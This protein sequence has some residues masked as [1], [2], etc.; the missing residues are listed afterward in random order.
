MVIMNDEVDLMYWM[1]YICI[2]ILCLH[3]VSLISNYYNY[4]NNDD[5]NVDALWATI[6]ELEDRVN[7]LEHNNLFNPTTTSIADENKA[8]E[9]IP[10]RKLKSKAK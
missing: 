4:N 7:G 5:D 2:S 3:I 10:I 6:A 8:K 1:I 9:N